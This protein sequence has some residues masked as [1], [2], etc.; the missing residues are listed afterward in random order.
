MTYPSTRTSN[1]YKPCVMIKPDGT[2]KRG[3]AA[4]IRMTTDGET[5]RELLRGGKIVFVS[6]DLYDS[7]FK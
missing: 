3:N 7:E 2:T 4:H 1:D 6:T 5:A